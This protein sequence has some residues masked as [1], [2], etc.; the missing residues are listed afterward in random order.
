MSVPLQRNFWIKS[1]V[2]EFY[3]LEI[4]MRVLIGVIYGY[5]IKL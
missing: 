1:A 3:A 2:I 4:L 5:D